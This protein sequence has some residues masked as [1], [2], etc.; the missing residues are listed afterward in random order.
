M[1][2]N[3]CAAKKTLATC[4][5]DAVVQRRQHAFAPQRGFHSRP[6][7][8]VRLCALFSP[9]GHWRRFAFALPRCG[10]HASTFLPPVPRRGFAFCASRGFSP[11][12]YHEGSDSCAAHLRAQVSPLTSPHLPVVPS[13]TTWAAWSSLT[14]HAS[15]TSEF[16]TSP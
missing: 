14:H 2:N 8:A 4:L 15:V 10:L 1:V 12:R 9:F 6:I 3:P 7:P 13:P 11:Q 5:F 16:R